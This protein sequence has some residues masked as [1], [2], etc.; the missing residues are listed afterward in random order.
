MPYLETLPELLESL[1]DSLGIDHHNLKLLPDDKGHAEDC[2][3][4][5]CWCRR[6]EQRIRQ[7]FA[8]EA[9][10]QTAEQQTGTTIVAEMQRIADMGRG[11]THQAEASEPQPLSGDES[12]AAYRQ[13]ASA[14]IDGAREVFRTRP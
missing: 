6:L 12:I 10:L 2:G 7:A 4:R 3:C 14:A 8:N 13:R 9:V 1:A 5:M 11:L